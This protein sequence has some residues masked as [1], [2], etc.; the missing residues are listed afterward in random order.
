M[1]ASSFLRSLFDPLL[2][3][4]SDDPLLRL[5]QIGLVFAGVFIIFTVFFT[6]RDILQR[7]HSFLLMAFC[8]MLVTFLPL[9]GFLLYFLLRPAE[10]LKM[11]AREA[12]LIEMHAKLLGTRPKKRS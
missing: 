2:L 8:I 3:F 12:M 7:T 6:T 10:T 1:D 9:I 5:A 11:R 4:L